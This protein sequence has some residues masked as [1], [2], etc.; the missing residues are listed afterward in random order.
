M[1]EA[2]RQAALADPQPDTQAVLAEALRCL[3]FPLDELERTITNVRT[4]ISDA[5]AY[6]LEDK[7]RF[8]IEGDLVP[9]EAEELR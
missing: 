6:F 9:V 7:I 8:R 3:G 2:L 1:I 4:S 5:G